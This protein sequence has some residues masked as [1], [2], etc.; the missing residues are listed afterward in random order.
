MRQLRMTLGLIVA[1]AL[2]TA[3]STTLASPDQLP[4][5]ARSFVDQGI[6]LATRTC[7]WLRG[8]PT[9]RRVPSRELRLRSHEARVP[10]DSDTT[11]C[12]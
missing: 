1:V 9:D 8:E 6:D 12:V 4:Y 11:R 5:P 10:S 7:L 2:C 3:A